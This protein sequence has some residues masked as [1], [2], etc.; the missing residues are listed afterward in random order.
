MS[1]RIY[2]LGNR[3]WNSRW[4]QLWYFRQLRQHFRQRY[5]AENLPGDTPWQREKGSNSH[6]RVLLLRLEAGLWKGTVREAVCNLEVEYGDSRDR[7]ERRRC[8]PDHVGHCVGLKGLE[9]AR[10]RLGLSRRR[11]N[12]YDDPHCKNVLFDVVQV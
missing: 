4:R 8:D 11:F 2:G 1:I 5:P 6:R 9:G 7:P 3:P 12:G 10:T